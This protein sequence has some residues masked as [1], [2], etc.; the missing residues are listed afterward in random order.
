MLGM[1]Q[2]SNEDRKIVFRAR[3]L[4]KFLTQPFF[5]TEQFTGLDGRN[6]TLHETI[7]GCEQILSDKFIDT[8][9]EDLYMIGSIS[10]VKKKDE[11]TA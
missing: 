5:T 11:V 7:D 2:L 3:L 4:E 9:E 10:D 6:V 1:E 8:S